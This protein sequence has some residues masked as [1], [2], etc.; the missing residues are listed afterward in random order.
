M[1]KNVKTANTARCNYW[2]TVVYPESAPENWVTILEDAIVPA[3]VSPLHDQD[4]N[5]DGEVKKEHYHV[6]LLFES[7]KSPAQ[8]KEI[9]D[10]IGG[11]G[12]ERVNSIRGYARYLCHL[13][14]PDKVRYSEDDVRAFAGVDYYN[15]ISLPTDRLGIIRDMQLFIRENKVH[16]FA[17]LCDYALLERDDWFRVLTESGTVYIKEYL[18]SRSWTSNEE[19]REL[20]KR[21][22]MAKLQKE[23]EDIDNYV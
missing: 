10:L 17:D 18:K 12:C 6:L 13:D 22:K 15:I 8:A 11:V 3:L 14:N 20:E 5:P 23:L 21:V 7:L 1:S 9:F 4:I 16:S 2:S 19:I